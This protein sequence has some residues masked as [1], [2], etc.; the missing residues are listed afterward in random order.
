MPLR[1]RDVVTALAAAGLIATDKKPADVE[2]VLR[3]L[4]ASMPPDE[5][6]ITDKKA[7][8]EKRAAD[9]KARDEKVAKDRKARDEA[10]AAKKAEDRKARDEKC[11]ADRAARDKAMDSDD[12]PEGTNDA[13]YDAEMDKEAADESAAEKE[14]EDSD[15]GGDPST[16]GGNRAGGKTAI[17]SGEVDKRIAAAVAQD[18]ALSTAR[19]AVLPVIGAVALDSAAAVYRAGL[20]GLG[21]DAKTITDETA[22]ATMFTMAKDKAATPAA[23][24]VVMD[25]AAVSSMEKIIPGYGRLK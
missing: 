7:R 5:K 3:A 19:A 22:L 4:D 23:P 14:A 20:K 21:I 17:D 6:K 16:P 10:F 24:A 18:R 8:D 2:A 9:R 12:D 1:L 25:S 13:A 15:M 11:A